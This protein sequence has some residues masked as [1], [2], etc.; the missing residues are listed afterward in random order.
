MAVV[1]MA[2]GFVH[3]CCYHLIMGAV[4]TVIIDTAVDK[5]CLKIVG[6]GY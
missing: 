4:V 3:S 1:V 2:F 5:L 6:W